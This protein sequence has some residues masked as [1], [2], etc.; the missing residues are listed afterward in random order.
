MTAKKK[1][2]D[3]AGDSPEVVDETPVDETT[4]DGE[5]AGVEPES[6]DGDN[7]VESVE[8][9]ETPASPLTTA[10]GILGVPVTGSMNHG[11]KMALRAFQRRAG[12]PQTG[13]LDSR[14]RGVMHF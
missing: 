9:A 4:A 14:T 7:P 11:T 1:A 6:T 13:Q 10:Q 12:I 2:D 5:T 8:S 3:E